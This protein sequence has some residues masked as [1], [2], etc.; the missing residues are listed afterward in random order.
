MELKS[1]I[2]AKIVENTMLSEDVF[3]MWIEVG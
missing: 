2:R 3:S 1:K